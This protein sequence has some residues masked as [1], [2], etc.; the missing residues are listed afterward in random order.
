MH[1]HVPEILLEIARDE[2]LAKGDLYNLSVS[3][4]LWRDIAEVVLWKDMQG[5]MPVLATIP[6]LYTRVSSSSS[7]LQADC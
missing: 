1:L 2:G 7:W 4:K 5:F 3:C 6:G